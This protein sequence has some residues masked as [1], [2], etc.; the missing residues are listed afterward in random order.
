MKETTTKAFRAMISI[1]YKRPV[2]F[3]NMSSDEVFELVN[4]AERYDLAKLKTKLKQELEARSLAKESVVEVAKTAMK[5]YQ[6]EEAS[7]ATLDNC[8]K[9]LNRELDTK[10]SVVNFTASYYGTGDEVIVMKLMSMIKKLQ[11][12]PCPNCQESPCKSGM[13]VTM[14]KQV[15]AGTVLAPNSDCSHYWN[16]ELRGEA[17][18]KSIDEDNQTVI[19]G[20]GNGADGYATTGYSVIYG[21]Y[22]VPRFRFHCRK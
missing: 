6:L 10:E 20:R 15:R 2:N 8:A 19:V 21:V 11:P 17:V 7:K 16:I 1:I 18:V 3:K 5:F 12:P 22:E 4:L 13:A 9:T 14:V